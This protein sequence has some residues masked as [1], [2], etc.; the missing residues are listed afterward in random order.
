MTI[1]QISERQFNEIAEAADLERGLTR[2]YYDARNSSI[3]VCG[4]E[5]PI[6][7]STIQYFTEV[8]AKAQETLSRFQKCNVIMGGAS[9]ADL[10]FENKTETT[11]LKGKSLDISLM[12]I[13]AGEGSLSQYP[14][15]AVEVGYSETY[16]MLKKDVEA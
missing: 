2:F 8:A 7:K 14:T 5:S 9:K 3:V 13:V 10:Y 12:V 4:N 11:S 6:H 15:I 1:K 16:K